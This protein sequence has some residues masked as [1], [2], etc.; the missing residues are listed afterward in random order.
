[1]PNQ[2]PDSSTWTEQIELKQ[3]L[4]SDHVPGAPRTIVWTLKWIEGPPDAP[5]GSRAKSWNLVNG[6]GGLVFNQR[7]IVTRFGESPAVMGDA[8]GTWGVLGSNVVRLVGY[9]VRNLDDEDMRKLGVGGYM[10]LQ[11]ML[12]RAIEFEVEVNRRPRRTRP[13]TA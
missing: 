9:D 10:V 1:M 5:R 7:S 3:L 13:R 4:K 6:L 8:W 11:K 12:A 2:A